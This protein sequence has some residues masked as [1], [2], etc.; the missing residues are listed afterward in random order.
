MRVLELPPSVGYRDVEVLYRAV[1]ADEPLL[2]DARRVE[3]VHPTGMVALLAA[4]KVARDRSGVASKLTLPEGRKGQGVSSY[5]G[6]SGF[7]RAAR[8]V[9][10][11]PLP[12]TSRRGR[13]PADTLLEVTSIATNPDVHKV[14]DHVQ[15]QA[16]VVLSDRLRYP[17]TS[18]VGFSLILAEACQNIVEHAQGSGWVAA[19]SYKRMPGL[20]RAA[21]VVAVSDVG[22]GFRASLA[23]RHAFRWG[24]RWGD[25]TALEAA[26]HKGLTHSGAPGRG[27]G[28]RQIRRQ[29]ESWDGLF[30]VRSGTARIAD[31][32]SWDAETPPMEDGLTPFPGA[33]INI[34]I[35]DKAER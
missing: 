13:R 27:H 21:V 6:S 31:A 1:S 34:V 3:W 11:S 20:P 23:E 33:Q 17:K 28:I 22:Q 12:S 30:S 24:D 14:V 35:P 29:I 26:F 9:F 8:E 25:V 10:D 2:F 5:L 32:P 4:A 16:A 7:L 18:L 19:Q 15:S